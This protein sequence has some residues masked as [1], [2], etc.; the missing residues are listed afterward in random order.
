MTIAMDSNVA[1]HDPEAGGVEVDL[2]SSMDTM[3]V[4]GNE[5]MIVSGVPEHDDWSESQGEDAVSSLFRYGSLR[6]SL[7]QF[8][9]DR[10]I[11]ILS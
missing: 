8:L 10:F 6:Y 9:Y 1:V 3:E 5:Q 2:N 7:T 11:I 4:S